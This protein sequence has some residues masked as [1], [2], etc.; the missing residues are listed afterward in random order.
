M[1]EELTRRLSIEAQEARTMAELSQ[2]SL[3]RALEMIDHEV[4][5][6][7]SK[8]VQSLIDLPG[9]DVQ[10]AFGAAE[11]LASLGEDLSL[12]FPIMISWYRDLI[13]WNEQGDVNRLTNQDFH[14]QIKERGVRLSRQDLVRR[15]EAINQTSKAIDRNVNRLLA[16]ESLM[17]Q[18][19]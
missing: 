10:Q 15:I 8:I 9:Q 11:S 2:G 5:E 6:R 14:E 17:L 19:R 16:M 12:V 3:G 18:L 13:I 7:R 4:W 1:V